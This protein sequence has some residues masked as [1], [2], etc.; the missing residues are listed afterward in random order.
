MPKNDLVRFSISIDWE[1]LKEFDNIIQKKGFENRS[2]AIRSILR[3]FI[4]SEKMNDSNAKGIFVIL[5]SFNNSSEVDCG[6]GVHVSLPADNNNDKR[7]NLCIINAKYSH[8]KEMLK[9]IRSNPSVE[10]CNLIPVDFEK[11]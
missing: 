1:L 9:K 11:E 5:A 7:L 4:C 3:E 6:K 10:F 2:F 8:A